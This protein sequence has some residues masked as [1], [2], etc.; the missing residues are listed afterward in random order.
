[1]LLRKTE[2]NKTPFEKLQF[3]ARG[4]KKRINDTGNGQRLMCVEAKCVVSFILE[5]HEPNLFGFLFSIAF[6]DFKC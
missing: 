4:E 3:K 2:N 5:V 1:M 6:I